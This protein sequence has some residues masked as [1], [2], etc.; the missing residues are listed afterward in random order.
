MYNTELTVDQQ[1]IG[2]EERFS[3]SLLSNTDI[4]TSKLKSDIA[5]NL[6]SSADTQTPLQRPYIYF[7]S[8]IWDCFTIGTHYGAYP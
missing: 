3:I 2:E 4:L 8:F 1:K 5:E 6:E 7:K